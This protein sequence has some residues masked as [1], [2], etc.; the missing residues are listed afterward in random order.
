MRCRCERPEFYGVVFIG[1]VFWIVFKQLNDDGPELFNQRDD[2]H[3][4]SICLYAEQVLSSVKALIF[5]FLKKHVHDDA[6]QQ[7]D[8]LWPVQ[9]AA[10]CRAVEQCF[11]SDCFDTAAACT[12]SEI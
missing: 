6:R 5:T 12:Q 9:K 8:C 11:M 10:N 1:E 4:Q 2:F 7:I 3:T